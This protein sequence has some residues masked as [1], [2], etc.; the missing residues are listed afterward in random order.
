MKGW[1]W[2]MAGGALLAALQ[3]ALAQQDQAEAALAQLEAETPGTLISDPTRLDW[4]RQGENV[5][6]AGLTDGAIPGGGAANRYTVR[7]AGPQPY[8]SQV[9]VPLVKAIDKGDTIT[10]GFW[11]RT[12][13][14]ET[15]TGQGTLGL[16]IQLNQD[17]WP[18]FADTVLAIGP[19]WKWHEVSATATI[20]IARDSGILAFHLG[21]ARQTIDIG[22]TIVVK[23]AA[24][25]AAQAPPP[26]AA[27][28]VSSEIP[29]PLK[30]AG[31]LINDPATRDW[32]QTG[33]DGA[34]LARAEPAVWLGQATRF[35]SP[36]GAARGTVTTAIPIAEAIANGDKL[37]V[38]MVARTESAD[39]I[40]NRGLVRIRIQDSQP[41]HDG[42]A[43]A[44]FNVGVNWQL[45]RVPVTAARDLPAGRAEVVL[46]FSA[47][48]QAIDIG[49]VYVFKAP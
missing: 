14:A 5:N 15:E 16:R 31:R 17:P 18:G 20:D 25:I 42:F 46:D 45:V 22:Q 26:A 7:R 33:P 1:R 40:D 13:R 3:P 48:G 24:A 11:A 28:A 36:A 38:A 44:A 2:I 43:D 4:E 39:T 37:V 21:G 10:V 32:R 19:E 9:N 8:S 27:A 35:T 29:E 23:G 12:E 47:A 30:S 41:P 34:S 6:V 49:P